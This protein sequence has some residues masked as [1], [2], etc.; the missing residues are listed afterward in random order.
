VIPGNDDSARA[1]SLYS[2]LMTDSILSGIQMQASLHTAPQASVG[3]E[4]RGPRAKAQATVT[5]SKAA[6]EVAAADEAAEAPAAAPVA[7]P[8]TEAASA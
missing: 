2:R 8:A 5:L 4:S 1:L 6:Q 7:A 3:G